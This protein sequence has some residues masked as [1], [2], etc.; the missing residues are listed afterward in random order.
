MDV[1]S[2][3][4]S[5]YQFNPFNYNPLKSLLEEIVDFE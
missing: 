1:L 3:F 5:P 4:S 2:Y